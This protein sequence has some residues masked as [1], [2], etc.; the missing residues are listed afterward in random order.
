LDF[1]ATLGILL[2]AV[3]V[4]LAVVTSLR[5]RSRQRKSLREAAAKLYS[6][7]CATYREEH[8]HRGVTP[9]DFPGIGRSG[10][11]EHDRFLLSEGFDAL[12][13]IENLT[14]NRVHPEWRTYQALYVSADRHTV[15]VTW[16]LQGLQ[17]LSFG[18]CT[19]DGQFLMTSNTEPSLLHWPA[20]VDNCILP[21]DMDPSG[22]LARHRARMIAFEQREPL[23]EWLAYDDIETV[24]AG[25]KTYW[26]QMAAHRQSIG[27]IT[28]SEMLALARNRAEEK[29][30]RRLWAE[31]RRQKQE[32]V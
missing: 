3:V 4:P 6:D 12:G 2:M 5:S 10:Y 20:T 16:C 13:A 28:L 8:E 22:M 30:A 18:C 15:A 31:I 24:L 17:Y 7:T 21:I 1:Q 19:A 32:E 14:M 25:F 9:E 27:Y 26:R 23:S 11:D 29:A